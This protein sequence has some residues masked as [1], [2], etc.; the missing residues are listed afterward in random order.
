MDRDD[1]RLGQQYSVGMRRRHQRDMFSFYLRLHDLCVVEA[2]HAARVIDEHVEMAQK[3][4]AKNSR[5][6]ER[7]SGDARGFERR[8]EGLLQLRA[9]PN[10]GGE[11][12]IEHKPFVSIFAI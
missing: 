7:L 4:T 9:G 2:E 12:V 1:E 11:L 10:G 6:A 8:P 3:V 5:C